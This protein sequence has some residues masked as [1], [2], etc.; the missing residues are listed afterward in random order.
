M[1]EASTRRTL[2]ARLGIDNRV[3][4]SRLAFHADRAARAPGPLE[5][6]SRAVGWGTLSVRGG[7][8]SRAE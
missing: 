1:T 8:T 7:A 3:C 6:A 5:S 2:A 4:Q